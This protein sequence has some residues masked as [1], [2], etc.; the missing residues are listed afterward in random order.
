MINS[1][2]KFLRA[3]LPT[4]AKEVLRRIQFRYKFRDVLGDAHFC[5]VCGNGVSNFTPLAA[6]CDGKFVRDTVVKHRRYPV[7]EYETL[8]VDQFL[9]P[10]CGAQDKARLYALYLRKVL[11]RYRGQEGNP[12]T[13]VHFAPEG[14]LGDLI[15]QYHSVNYVTADLYRT[16]VDEKVD[17]TNMKRYKSDSINAFICSHV[18]EHI[19]DDSKA[20]SELHRVLSVDGWGILMVP[21]LLPLDSTYEDPTINTDEG[22]LDA[23]GLEDHVRVYAKNDF[24]N[25]LV[26]AGF[27]VSEYGKAYFGTQQFARCGI[28]EKS[29][30]Y[31]VRKR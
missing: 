14:G 7:S 2:K 16:D 11:E 13:L 3:I 26:A 21:I 17:I 30:L 6:I 5:P 20:L 28:T 8:N 23:F 4:R 15:R 10:I 18:L 24:K 27:V 9:C 31:V 1:S 29:V 19:Q 22:R 12:I 25:K